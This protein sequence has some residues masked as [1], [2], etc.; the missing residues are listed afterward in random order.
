MQLLRNAALCRNMCND[1][2]WS[3]LKAYSIAARG[4]VWSSRLHWNG[5]ADTKPSLHSA[6]DSSE[7]PL[8]KDYFDQMFNIVRDNDFC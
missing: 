1:K 4:E 8:K 3:L 7:E 2:M 6:V 5:S